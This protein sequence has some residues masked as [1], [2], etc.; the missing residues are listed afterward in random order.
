MRKQPRPNNRGRKSRVL[1]QLIFFRCWPAASNSRA[2][3]LDTLAIARQSAL[4]RSL[5]APKMQSVQF[6]TTCHVTLNEVEGLGNSQKGES[7]A[8][9]TLSGNAESTLSELNGLSMT[10]EVP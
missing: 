2:I 4:D 5:G 10:S 7:F 1:Y 8:A 9:T 6:R 3:L